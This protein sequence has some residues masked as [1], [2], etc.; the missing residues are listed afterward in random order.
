[1]PQR[2][3][4]H[5]QIAPAGETMQHGREGALPA[6]FLQN[7]RH[8]VIGLA[9]MDHQRQAGLARR[10]DMGAKALFLRVARAVVVVIV[11]PGLADR[12]HF[13]MPRDAGELI[14]ADVELFMGVVRMRA[15]RAK[16]IGKALGDRQHL[17]VAAHPRRDRHHAADAGRAR[18]RNHGVEFG[19]EIGKIEMAVAVDQHGFNFYLAVASGST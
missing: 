10:R 1:M 11:E 5:G 2:H 12:H 3:R 14:A 7:A 8:V 17:R 16:N 6:F 18:P 19:G 4:A 15:D 13:R 9:R